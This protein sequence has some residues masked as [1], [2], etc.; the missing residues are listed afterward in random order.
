MDGKGEGDPDV[1]DVHAHGQ[2]VVVLCPH[3]RER[4]MV[5]GG[6]S[7]EQHD[8]HV[9]EEL[10]DGDGENGADRHKQFLCMGD[11][12]LSFFNRIRID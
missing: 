12:K 3:Q 7:S 9:E 6:A 8:Q 1:G 5:S 2:V 11:K 10:G 4:Q